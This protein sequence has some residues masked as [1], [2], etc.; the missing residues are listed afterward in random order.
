VVVPEVTAGRERAGLALEGFDI[1]AAVPGAVTDQP[2]QAYE[3]IRRDLIPYFGLPFYRAMI[4]RTGFAEDIA[5]Y[6]AA[7]GD[8]P[9]MQ[10]AISDA[11]LA[12]L[13][14]VGDEQ[15]VRAGLERYRAA[16]AVSPCIG[17]IPRTDFEA[18]LQAAA[19]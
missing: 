18:T 16:G 8:L 10:A 9:A 7:A 5:S 12:E 3:A 6:D 19:G 13:T 1:V 15:G 11:F 4:E 2:E 14:A 17:P